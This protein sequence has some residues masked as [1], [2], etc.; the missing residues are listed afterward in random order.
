MLAKITKSYQFEDVKDYEKFVSG[1]FDAI[2]K[3]AK[4]LCGPD[5]EEEYTIEHD[6]RGKKD[7]VDL[8]TNKKIG[9]DE[10]ENK[11]S[12]VHWVNEYDDEFE[13]TGEPD[14]YWKFVIDVEFVSDIVE[15]CKNQVVAI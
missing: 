5:T 9:V 2:M 14:H 8:E 7:I 11:I 13:R 6:H 12:L 3:H 10:G 15:E 1:S 4:M